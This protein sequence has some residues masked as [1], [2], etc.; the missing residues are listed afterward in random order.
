R[1]PAITARMCAT[2]MQR[3]R[4]VQLHNGTHMIAEY[5]TANNVAVIR[6]FRPEVSDV[7]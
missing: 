5:F 7:F 4:G 2:V 6:K 1:L 3:F